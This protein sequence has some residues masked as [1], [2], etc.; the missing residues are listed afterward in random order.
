M[1]KISLMLLMLCILTTSVLAGSISD[2]QYKDQTN[3][4][5]STVTRTANDND[6]D[7]DA[8]KVN[9]K[10]YSD[11]T[12]DINSATE[13]VL[14]IAN[15]YATRNDAKGIGK[16]SMIN[17]LYKEFVP[18]LKSIFITKSELN[19]LWTYAY[20]TRAICEKRTVTDVILEDKNADFVTIKNGVVCL[21]Y[22]QEYY[23]RG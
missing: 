21:E 20:E 7:I 14:L 19:K 13:T 8:D 12:S 16:E 5:G 3:V 6:V 1:R 9:G 4:F 15:D 23:C 2:F 18:Y 22:K 17:Y 10:S 11:I